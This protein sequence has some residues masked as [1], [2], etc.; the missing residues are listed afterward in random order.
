MKGDETVR[1]RVARATERFESWASF[2][3]WPL[4]FILPFKGLLWF[5]FAVAAPTAVT[6]LVRKQWHA[7]G[8]IVATPKKTDAGL[9][10]LDASGAIVETIPKTDVEAISTTRDPKKPYTYLRVA[11]KGQRALVFETEGGHDL[12]RVAEALGI[13]LGTARSHVRGAPI[14]GGALVMLAAAG[15]I[16]IFVTGR[17]SGLTH[18]ALLGYRDLVFF[19]A[20]VALNITTLIELGPDGVRW[21]WLW[22][23]RYAAYREMASVQTEPANAQGEKIVFLRIRMKDGTRHTLPT[24]KPA[25]EAT[26][27]ILTAF[28]AQDQAPANNEGT[29]ASLARLD[30]ESAADWVHRLRM[31][32]SGASAYRAADVA[33]LW[34][35]VENAATPAG[36]RCAAALVLATNDAARTRLRSIETQVVDPDVRAVLSALANDVGET[37]L[38]LLFASSTLTSST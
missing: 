19:P 1:F 20:L 18:M 37:D 16:G 17:T 4:V 15:F 9:E 31:Q 30:G 24:G 14:W 13:D 21:R 38:A 2:L 34:P 33:H 10:L 23:E 6:W 29:N 7:A 5:F 32:T 26:S 28:A 12:A 11:R 36:L 27:K 25:T 3:T 35:L 8:P 22:W